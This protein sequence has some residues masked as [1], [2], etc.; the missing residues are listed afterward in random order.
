MK[1]DNINVFFSSRENLKNN[2][3]V[4]SHFNPVSAF[5]RWGPIADLISKLVHFPVNLPLK[6]TNM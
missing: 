5:L 6:P 4:N 1:H 2:I 3:L